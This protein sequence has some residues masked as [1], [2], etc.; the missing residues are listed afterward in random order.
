MMKLYK[1][2]LFIIFLFVNSISS[3]AVQSAPEA[4]SDSLKQKDF[5]ELLILFWK[6][7]YKDSIIK[8]RLGKAYLKKAKEA[9][10]PELIANGYQ[11]LIDL[12]QDNLE[13][14]LIYVDSIIKTTYL[15][16]KNFY[17]G[18]GYLMKGNF[19]VEK[20]EFE[21]ALES[22]L[23][24]KKIAE[25]NANSEQV[26]VSEHKIALV[27]LLLGKIEEA[28]KVFKSHYDR[29]LDQN[30]IRT[31]SQL[32]IGTMY[33]LIE[34]YH[35]RKEY[36]TS[37]QLIQNGLKYSKNN[38]YGHYYP[39]LL[40]SF[41]V[42]RFHKEEYENAVDSLT[43]ALEVYPATSASEINKCYLYLGKS[44]VKLK[45]LDKAKLNLEL[46]YSRITN[47]N[48][49]AENRE[50]FELLSD[51]YKKESNKTKLVELLSTWIDYEQ[52]FQEEYNKIE[53]LIS[54]KY[55]I[56]DLEKQRQ[57]LLQE[58]DAARANS[59]IKNIL[60]LMFT[61]VFLILGALFIRKSKIKKEK[62]V[63][64]AE[65][66][67]PKNIISDELRFEILD[68]LLDFE[69]QKLFLKNDLTLTKTA[70]KLNTNSSYL[71]KVI[72]T[73]KKKNFTNY[74]NDLRI[75]HC[76]EQIHKNDVF[77]QYSVRAMAKEVGFNNIQSFVKAFSK[78]MNCNPANYLNRVSGL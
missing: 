26:F 41:G 45:R 28:H 71:S 50:V 73:E 7:H 33:R 59:M 43:R 76:L 58:I 4:T 20:G 35:K 55:E 13:V 9:N 78:K 56:P 62:V 67:T 17:P 77:K 51:I 19:L 27:K 38:S 30:R 66:E 42:N 46:L 74:I 6:K 65:P 11:M 5:H 60:I 63:T 25:E 31:N 16:K 61:G 22:Y 2:F 44:F 34:T 49:D 68:K 12:Y 1:S 48:F 39:E 14:S 10:S 47:T 70:K 72:N 18:I 69:R 53:R 36:D 32:Y 23:L 40:Y 57:D 8:A 52:Q 75:D 3:A 15:L 21:Q 24:A 37:Y 64:E 29:L 54:L